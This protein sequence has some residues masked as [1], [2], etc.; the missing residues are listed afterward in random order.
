M[1]PDSI[2]IADMGCGTGGQSIALAKADSRINV[3]AVD[4]FPAMIEVLNRRVAEE[5]L[6]Y[7]VSGI[8][9]SMDDLHEVDNKYDVIW[10]EGS[11]Y[12]IGFEKG[13]NLWRNYLKPGGFVAVSD[14]VWLTEERPPE[15]EDYL[16]RNVPEIASPSVKMRQIEK[17][18]YTPVSA[19]LQSESS[20]E[21]SFYTPAYDLLEQF[22]REYDFSQPAKEFTD[23]MREE[24]DYYRRYKQYF[25]YMFYVARKQ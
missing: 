5:G 14:M 8:I 2:L 12:N 19:F 11:I 17:A 21:D 20:W 7:K 24:I 15:L 10:S 1:K 22:L 3:E 13:M 18:G 16:T 9:G 4:L 25:G 23:R 6:C